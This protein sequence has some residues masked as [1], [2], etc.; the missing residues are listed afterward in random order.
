MTRNFGNAA[1]RGAYEDNRM[2]LIMMGT[3]PFAV[4]TFEALYASRHEVAGP[5]DRRRCVHRGKAV[6]P[7]SPCARSPP[8]GKRRSSTPKALTRPRPKRCCGDYR[9]DLAVV[10]DYGQILAPATLG[11]L[12]AGRH[13]SARLAVAQVSRGGPHQLGHLSWPDPHG[14]TVIHMSPRIDAGPCIAQESTE[15]GP[16]ETAASLET[17]L[18]AMGARLIVAAVDALAAGPV[19]SLPQ[20]PAQASPAP[21]LKKTDGAIDWTRPAAAIKNQI[22]AL[23]ALAQDVHL[24]ASAGRS[25]G[26]LDLGAGKVTGSWP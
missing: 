6:E 18:A 23:G 16:E 21:R 12:P 5:G 26:P 3:G 14:V 25:A 19:A 20:D 10:C 24:L 22:R 17:R 8:S 11:T 1:A 7:P 13:Q 2:R 4:P 9:A 15:I